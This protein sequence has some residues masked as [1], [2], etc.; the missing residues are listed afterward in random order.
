MT[1]FPTRLL[2]RSFYRRTGGEENRITGSSRVQRAAGMAGE[3][4]RRGVVSAPGQRAL[5]HAFERPYF[6]V[7]LRVVVLQAGDN[8]VRQVFHGGI[9]IDQVHMGGVQGQFEAALPGVITEM[10]VVH[11]AG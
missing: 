7:V 2:D 8:M 11:A 1:E 9:R 4:W 10:A 6:E 3:W 5:H